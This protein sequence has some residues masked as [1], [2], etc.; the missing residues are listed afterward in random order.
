M[1]RGIS[2]LIASVILVGFVVVL[3]AFMFSN[4]GKVTK[5]T[6]ET[7]EGWQSSARLIDF[8]VELKPTILCADVSY[9]I[10]SDKEFSCYVVLI[11][12]KMAEDISYIV[13]TIGDDGVD[14]CE[15][16]IFEPFTSKMVAVYIEDVGANI[17]A[18]IVPVS[19]TD[20]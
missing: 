7:A 6:F 18:E 1:K 2:P 8:E 10:C 12:N 17:K 11:E 19:Y 20:E 15:T 13:R 16:G 14:V 3:A 9:K 4:M 5:G